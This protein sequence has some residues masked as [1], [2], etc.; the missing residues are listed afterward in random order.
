MEGCPVSMTV[1]VKGMTCDH[2][3]RTVTQALQRLPGLTNVR[4][5]LERS[6]ATCDAV[7][8]VDWSVVRR[9]MEDA[10]YTAVLPSPQPTS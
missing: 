4:V 8:P 2:C 3:V 10:G 6:E 7:G 1:T 9:A 5:D